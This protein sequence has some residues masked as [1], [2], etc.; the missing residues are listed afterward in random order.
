M[1][2]SRDSNDVTIV[3]VTTITMAVIIISFS[4][5]CSYASFLDFW[6]HS[7]YLQTTDWLPLSGRGFGC[8]RLQAD[9]VTLTI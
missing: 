4:F 2:G 3:I 6:P 1:V 8:W 5:L 7:L 9:I